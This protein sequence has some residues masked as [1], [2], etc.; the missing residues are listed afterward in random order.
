M[1]G[2]RHSQGEWVVYWRSMGLLSG[3]LFGRPTKSVSGHMQVWGLIT[4]HTCAPGGVS[5]LDATTGLRAATS[6]RVPPIFGVLELSGGKR[7]APGFGTSSLDARS[8]SLPILAEW[9]EAG[10]LTTRGLNK[11]SPAYTQ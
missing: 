3:R 1:A 8:A 4:R 10:G 6:H 5:I 2:L 7:R 11:T 9:L